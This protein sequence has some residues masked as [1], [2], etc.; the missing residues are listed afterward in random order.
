MGNSEVG[1]TN[2]G[3]GRVVYQMLVKITKD[4]G[5]G[6]FFTKPALVHSMEN[7]RDN[8]TALHLMGLLSPGGVHSH[9]EHLYGLL[10][11]AKKYGLEKVFVHAFLDGRDVPPSSAAEYM[12]EL[13][14]KMKEIGVG[15]VA[16]VSGR[17]YAMDRDN[18]WDRVEKAY[19]AMVMGEGVQADCPVA[20]I[21]DSYK[22]GVT[23]E[24]MLPTVVDKNGMIGRKRFCDLL[25][26]PS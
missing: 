3:A 19:D 23:D 21:E 10:Q 16:T 26:L 1:H 17:Y 6:E 7:A 5:D 22:N 24:F 8:G 9:Q 14:E 2:I 4:I 12:R 25:Q 15:S 13:V 18:A 11:M 20:A